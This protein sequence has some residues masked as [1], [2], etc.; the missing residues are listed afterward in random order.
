[1]ALGW[2]SWPSVVTRA[3][4]WRQSAAPLRHPLAHAVSTC[5]VKRSSEFIRLRKM[6]AR[7]LRTTGRTTPRD[8]PVRLTISFIAIPWPASARMV[9]FS[10]WRRSRPACGGVR[11][12][13]AAPD[14][15]HRHHGGTD[16]SHRPLHGGEERGTGV[17]HQ[18][19]S[20]RH[21]NG[22]RAILGSSLDVAGATIAG[23]DAAR[24][25]LGEPSGDGCCLAIEKDVD[26]ATLFQ[27]QMIVP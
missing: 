23:D 21:L 22:F 7:P 14:Q 12:N 19:P 1:M 15:R 2:P 3:F 16:R 6:S 18:V 10:S 17:P 26:D 27:S 11:R 4:T 24:G 9:V 25:M 20:V 5:L 13:S 8:F